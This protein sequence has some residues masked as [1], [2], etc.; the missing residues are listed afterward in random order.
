MEELF[1]KLIG[2]Y[3]WLLVSGFFLIFFK[4]FMENLYYGLRFFLGSDFSVDDIVYVNDKKCRI[5]RQSI[6][7]TTF[8]IIEEDKKFHIPN[9]RLQFMIIEKD[10][11]QD[12]K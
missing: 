9:N 11:K 1:K 12:G 7:K 6:F 10:L 4:G 5:A 3:G 2:E 8:Y